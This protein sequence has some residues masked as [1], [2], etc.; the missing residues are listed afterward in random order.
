MPQTYVLL[1]GK[2]ID[3]IKKKLS[4]IISAQTIVTGLI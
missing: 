1:S 3:E 2:Q 4:E